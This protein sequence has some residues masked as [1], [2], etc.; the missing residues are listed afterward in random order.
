MGSPELTGDVAS[1]APAG[2]V[3]AASGGGGAS[4]AAASVAVAGTVAA[5][6]MVDLD[7]V[8]LE[9]LGDWLGLAWLVLSFIFLLIILILC[10][11]LA[12]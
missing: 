2:E 8:A 9:R 11:L 7:I 3:P 5:E 10:R 4:A 6:K 12:S 1:A